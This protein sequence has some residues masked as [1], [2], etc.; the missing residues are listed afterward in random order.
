MTCTEFHTYVRTDPMQATPS[1]MMAIVRHK[2]TCE[3]CATFISERTTQALAM[4][5]EKQKE[6]LS[7]MIAAKVHESLPSMFVD[8]ECGLTK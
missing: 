6:A 1:L 8:P 3:A 4:M 2:Q 7:Q 5:T